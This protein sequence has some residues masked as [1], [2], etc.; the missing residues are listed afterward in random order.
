MA[1]RSRASLERGFL[2]IVIPRRDGR[3]RTLLVG[4]FVP[5]PVPTRMVTGRWTCRFVPWSEVS[6][7]TKTRRKD[8]KPAWE[9]DTGYDEDTLNALF[10]GAE[11][12]FSEVPDG[13]GGFKKRTREL[14]R[15]QH[16]FYIFFCYIHNYPTEGYAPT[17]L[18]TSRLPEVSLDTFY[19]CIMPVARNW[20]VQVDHIRLV[21][22]A[23]ILTIHFSNADCAKSRWNERLD[24][25][26][27]HGLPVPFPALKNCFNLLDAHTLRPL[28]VSPSLA[29]PGCSA[30]SSL[31]PYRCHRDLGHNLYSCM[32]G[33]GTLLPKL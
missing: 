21:D 22:N 12:F 8:G 23:S 24:P 6:A 27:H 25:M 9:A 17:A 31:F 10:A 28:S 19:K 11:P 1:G 18:R 13:N 3:R 30:R 5:F 20:S 4:E 32:W 15:A 33:G 26:N 2:R 16:Y 14:W 7:A 29:S